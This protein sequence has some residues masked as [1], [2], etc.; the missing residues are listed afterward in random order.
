MEQLHG[1]FAAYL[2]NTYVKETYEAELHLYNHEGQCKAIIQEIVAHEDAV[3][4][5]VYEGYTSINDITPAQLKHFIRSRANI[6]LQSMHMSPEYE[7][8]GIDAI[9]VWFYKGIKSIKV[10]D[11]FA[12]STTQYRKNWK[13]DNLSRLAHMKG[14]NV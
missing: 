7:L 8:S 6:L 3:I 4:D 9:A 13:T 1:D 5:Y 10:H 2:H 12:A 11:F 14:N